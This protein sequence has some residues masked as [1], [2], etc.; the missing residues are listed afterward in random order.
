MELKLLGMENQK[1][2]KS[3]QAILRNQTS[4][5]LNGTCLSIPICSVSTS[6]LCPISLPLPGNT[7]LPG[8]LG[9]VRYTV[10]Q[11]HSAQNFMVC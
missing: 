8:L 9:K 7:L 5:S 4:T 3:V 11:M 10:A 2:L 1:R 6:A